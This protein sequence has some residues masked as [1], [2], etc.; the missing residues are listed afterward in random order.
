M[1]MTDLS[2]ISRTTTTNSFGYFLFRNVAAG[3][4]YTFEA[5]AKNYNFNGSAR[6]FN[7]NEEIDDI[8]L[9][10]AE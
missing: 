1:T 7:I 9:V 5:R 10:S 4:A 2:G 6:V 8:K 3:N